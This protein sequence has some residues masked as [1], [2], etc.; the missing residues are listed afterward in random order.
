MKRY[1]LQVLRAFSVLI[2]FLYHLDFQ[3][4][5]G[6]FI[7]VDIFFVLSGFFVAQMLSETDSKFKN[8]LVFFHRRLVRLVPNLVFYI[9]LSIPFVVILYPP[10]LIK[11]FG[12]SIVSN[13][14]F[15]SNIFFYYETDYYDDFSKT[16]P[17]LHTWSLALEVQYYAVF[18]IVVLILGRSR[19]FV[20]IFIGLLS[21]LSFLLAVLVILDDKTAVFYMLHYRF[22]ELAAGYFAFKFQ[23]KLEIRKFKYIVAL[24]LYAILTLISIGYSKSTVF[25]AAAALPVI[26][27][28]FI[29]LLIKLDLQ[30][31]TIINRF[32]IGIGDRSY[33][34]YLSHNILIAVVSTSFA[35]LSFLSFICIIISGTVITSEI[36]YKFVERKFLRAPPQ[37]LRVY[38]PLLT[39]LIL[40]VT[41]GYYLHK[42]NG[43]RSIKLEQGKMSKYFLDYDL[44]RNQRVAFVKEE[45]LQSERSFGTSDNK[46]LILGDSKSEDLF[47]LLKSVNRLNSEYRR[48]RLDDNCMA[49]PGRQTLNKLCEGELNNVINSALL[50]NANR[51]ILTATWQ[52]KN[53]SRIVDFVQYLEKLGKSVAIVSTANFQDASSIALYL[54][55]VSEKDIRSFF[56]NSIRRDWRR[57]YLELKERLMENTS[58]QFFEKLEIFCV[59]AEENCNLLS[60]NLEWLIYDSGH[61]TVPGFRELSRATKL[62]DWGQFV[63]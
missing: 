8:I 17:L 46:I 13:S 32:L 47:I 51:I 57:Q 59:L 14:I 18:G 40:I 30:V 55:S 43:L 5:K 39:L 24:I 21:I 15:L 6:G 62:L 2:V 56:H 53:I 49:A 41:S 25:P 34:I 45:I 23:H 48:L 50:E 44:L 1:D 42:T 28:T 26:I 61:L 63:D 54:H 31:N 4:F 33:S 9:L 29:L 3:I 36:S 35:Y 16:A 27:C 12:Q 38:L 19:K 58:A 20:A 10:H 22:W 52:R 11:D 7:G 37:F 60:P